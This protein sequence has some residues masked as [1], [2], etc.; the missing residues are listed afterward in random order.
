MKLC[1]EV[2]IVLVMTFSLFLKVN[3]TQE[4]V[5]AVADRHQPFIV[6]YGKMD[7]PRKVALLSENTPVLEVNLVH[8]VLIALFGL[9]YSMNYEYSAHVSK[10]FQFLQEYWLKI[11]CRGISD[12][13]KE[14]SLYL[15]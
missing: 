2:L 4:E 1:Y 15:K 9:Y 11:P 8:Q 13:A 3:G 10:P 14:L 5:T 12:S 7:E 6:I